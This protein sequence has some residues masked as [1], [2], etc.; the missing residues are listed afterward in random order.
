MGTMRDR[1]GSRTGLAGAALAS[2]YALT[3]FLAAGAHAETIEPNPIASASQTPTPSASPRPAKPVAATRTDK[4]RNV[5]EYPTTSEQRGKR[6][7]YDK[8]LMTVWL[9]DG[10]EKVVAR[11]PVVGRPDRPA[12]GVY[13]VYSKSE[14]SANPIQKLTFNN[15]VRFAY[16][17]STGAS[18]GFHDIPRTYDGRPIHGES[19]LG[20]PLGAGGCVRMA[21]GDSQQVYD[22]AKIG[23]AVEV[24]GSS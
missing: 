14:R 22:F 19:L 1:L 3:F 23:T 10:S 12:A 4:A 6:I 2:I 9:I 18:I 24:V 17:Q 7:V 15:M 21:T 11:F 5:P 20:L 13:T 16:G 8:S